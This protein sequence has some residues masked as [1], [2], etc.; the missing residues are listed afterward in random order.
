MCNFKI[1]DIII[2]MFKSVYKLL[3]LLQVALILDGIESYQWTFS[4]II[5]D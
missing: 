4:K 2:I 5:Y 1:F 3:L